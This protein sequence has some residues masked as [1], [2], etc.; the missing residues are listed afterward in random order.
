M[1][2]VLVTGAN[3]YLGQGLVQNLTEQ[4]YSVRATARKAPPRAL[5]GEFIVADL[6]ASSALDDLVESVDCV[7]HLAGLAHVVGRKSADI[8]TFRETNCTMTLQLAERALQS[9]VRRFIYISSIGVNGACTGLDPFTEASTVAPHANYAVSKLEAEQG[10][11]ELAQSGRMD[12]VIIRPPL[13]YS[14]SA[15]GNFGR[16][17][18]LIGASMPLPFALTKNERSMIALENIVDFI[19]LC[20]DHP[21]AANELFLIADDASVSTPQLIRYLAEGM[22]KKALLFPF[23]DSLIRFGAGVVGLGSVYTQLCGSL[24]IDSSKAQSILGWR[25]KVKPE[26][27]LVRAGEVYAKQTS[28]I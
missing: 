15:P 16:L 6:L 4:G 13:I 22:G 14:A 18:R 27:A 10:L 3:G 25:P 1:R 28:R 9:K 7:V 2:N 8:E 21:A 5:S 20:I 24:V 19:T 17:M 12:V 26:K 23:P 11:W